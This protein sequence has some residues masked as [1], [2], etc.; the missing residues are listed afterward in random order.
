MMAALQTDLIVRKHNLVNFGSK[1]REMQYSP[2]HV[3]PAAE[4]QGHTVAV[5]DTVVAGRSTVLDEGTVAGC[6]VLAVRTVLSEDT[7]LAWDT[8]LVGD[9]VIGRRNIV[10]GGGTSAM[11]LSEVWAGKTASAS[12]A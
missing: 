4:L 5:G 8:V 9:A 11:G 7:V 2:V 3:T 6:V 10:A 1:Y 12:R